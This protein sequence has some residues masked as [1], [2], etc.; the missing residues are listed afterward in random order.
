MA[1]GLTDAELFL[2]NVMRNGRNFNDK[3]SYNPK[4]IAS[5]CRD[6]YGEDP[7]DVAQRLVSKDYLAPK[8]KKDIKYWISNLPKT[9]NALSQHGYNVCER[10]IIRRN[11]FPLTE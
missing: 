7:N 8:R 1:C 6:K 10:R 11:V 9:Y 3:A 2:L 5:Q 4:Q